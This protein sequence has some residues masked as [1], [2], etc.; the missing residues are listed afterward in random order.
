MEEYL[1][2]TVPLRNCVLWPHVFL[3]VLRSDVASR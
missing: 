3:T 1:T 2:I